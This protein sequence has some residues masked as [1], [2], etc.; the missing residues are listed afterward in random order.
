MCAFYEETGPTRKQV[1]DLLLQKY[2]KTYNKLESPTIKSILEESIPLDKNDF[3][4]W[5]G[6]VT[7]GLSK[8]LVE[9]IEYELDM[10]SKSD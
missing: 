5:R 10:K 4:S 3:G 1:V 2:E 6:W 8:E 7:F 9:K